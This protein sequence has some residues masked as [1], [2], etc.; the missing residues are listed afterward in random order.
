[1]PD[2]VSERKVRIGI[3]VGGTTTNIGVIKNGRPGVDYAQI[4]GHDT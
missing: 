4:G 3:D 2:E 1:M